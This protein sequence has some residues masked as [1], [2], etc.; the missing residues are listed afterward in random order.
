M[1]VVNPANQELTNSD[2]LKLARQVD[3]LGERTIAVLTKLDI[4]DHGT[5]GKEILENKKSP[6]AIILYV[7]LCHR[8]WQ[9]ISY[10]ARS[11]LQTTVT[12]DNGFLTKG[13]NFSFLLPLSSLVLTICF[14]RDTRCVNTHWKGAIEVDVQSFHSWCLNITFVLEIKLYKAVIVGVRK[15][16]L[17]ITF[18]L[19][20]NSTGEQAN[21]LWE[22][23]T[24][25]FF[26]SPHFL[27]AEASLA[28]TAR[29]DLQK[30]WKIA[31]AHFFTQKISTKNA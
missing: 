11:F 14:S 17:C 18:A 23:A 5:D 8:L 22:Q 24:I 26:T 16:H 1:L 4:M 13:I 10:R 28:P 12:S 21:M 6:Q 19:E 20:L 31:Q 25:S 7:C 30:A 29:S 15:Y 9:R 3:R 27:V 2:V